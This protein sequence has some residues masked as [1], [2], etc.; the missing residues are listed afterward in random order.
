MLEKKKSDE[1]TIC[2]FEF[3]TT[4]MDSISVKISDNLKQKQF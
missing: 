2:Y 4:I 1:K 3:T